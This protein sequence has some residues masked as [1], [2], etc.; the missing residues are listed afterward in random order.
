[1]E[2][3]K[4]IKQN[5]LVLNSDQLDHMVKGITEVAVKTTLE[6]INGNGRT[7]WE[8]FRS[9]TPVIVI[10]SSSKSANIFVTPKRCKI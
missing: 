9:L 10:I 4:K 1:M 8:K 5:V 7:F 2:T 3:E 6:K